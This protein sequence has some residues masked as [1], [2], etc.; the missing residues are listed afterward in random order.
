[1]PGTSHPPTGRPAVVEARGE[2]HLHGLVQGI[3]AIIWERDAGGRFTFV[4]ASAEAILGYPVDEWYRTPDFWGAHLHADDRERATQACLAACEAR[5]P[6]EQEFRMIAANGEEVWLQ[7]VVTFAPGDELRL[8][9]VMHDITERKRA[10][11][12]LRHSQEERLRRAQGAASI[13]TFDWNVHTNELVWDGVEPIHGLP[14]GS[15]GGTFEAYLRDIHPEDKDRVLASIQEAV[16]SGSSVSIEYRIILPDGTLRWVEGNGRALKDDDG[17]VARLAGTC[18]DVTA[19]HAADEA[20]RFQAHLLDVIG[21]AVIATDLDGRIQYW[22]RAAE[23]LY[24]WRADEVMGRRIREV[25]VPVATDAT[26]D[27]VIGVIRREMPWSGELTCR[28]KDGGQVIVRVTDSPIRDTGGRVIGTIGVSRDIG[29]RRAAEQALEASEKRYRTLANALPAMVSLTGADG[30]AIFLNTRWYEYTGLS[31]EDM[32]GESWRRILHPEDLAAILPRW[33][34]SLRSRESIEIEARLRRHDGEY[35]W[36]L[37]RTVPMVDDGGELTGML[38]TAVDIHDRMEAERRIAELNRTLERK[39]AE[40]RT[41]LDIAPVGIGIAEDPE[42]KVIR[43]NSAF[44]R[45]LGVS[46]DSN[47]SMSAPDEIMPFKLMH[48]GV[49]VPAEDLPMQRAAFRGE[50]IAGVELDVLRADG[51]TVRL[52]E[53]AAPMRDA[54]G[55]IIGSVGAFVDISERAQADRSIR[56][57]ARATDVLNST[58]DY[59][60]TLRQLARLVVPEIAD[61]CVVDVVED[62]GTIRRLALAN[63]D[64]DR[65]RR[66]RD[67]GQQYSIDANGTSVQARTIRSGVAQFFPEVTDE[68]IDASAEDGRQAELLKRAG[69]VSFACLPLIARGRALGAITFITAESRRKLTDADFD[70]ARDLATRAAIAMDNAR[71]FGEAQQRAEDLRR[72]NEA[73]DEFLGLVSHE[74]R[75]PITTIFGNAQVLRRRERELDEESRRTAIGDIEQEA[76][77]LHR[78]VENMLTLARIETGRELAT[79]PVLAPRVAHRLAE[80]HML[81]FPRRRVVIDAAADLPA[82]LAEP[83]YLEQ[84]IRN[85][86]SNAEKYSPPDAPIDVRLEQREGYVCVAVLDR[87]AGIDPEEAGDLFS[88]FYR[89]RRTSGQASGVGMGLAVCKRL[90]EAQSG[91]VWAQPRQGG[92]SEIGFA[93]PVVKEVTS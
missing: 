33:E 55:N 9:G 50:S 34:E 27:H 79:E 3:G 43:A 39:L 22:N 18:M 61:W 1:M 47:T 64:P 51:V 7:D 69:I 65:E 78:I 41:V 62:G 44:A 87:G 37:G 92:G 40:L 36:H 80:A 21:E 38:I 54:E 17:R 84:V 49:D 76:D 2:S 5:R 73:K 26:P 70:L 58:L 63:A 13:G 31:P 86:L 56:F 29:A 14:P 85:L 42:C 48:N 57:L 74:L 93:L 8:Q 15:F 25:V 83:T 75:T 59:E 46:P 45:L 32:R 52:L 16:A 20:N 4:S 81:R 28:T 24:G 12:A 88:A 30:R 89:S 60:D 35:R 67:L 19:R 23:S 10:E 66:V 68:I 72:A 11:L 71:L 91:R 82:M 53:Y 77:R 6:F 90:V